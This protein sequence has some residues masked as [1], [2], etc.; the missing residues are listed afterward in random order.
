LAALSQGGGGRFR[1]FHRTTLKT[2]L[3]VASS[4]S[5][6]NSF[7]RVFSGE[8]GAGGGQCIQ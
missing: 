8:G 3:N 4:I 5:L 1:Y 2:G 7:L 6:V